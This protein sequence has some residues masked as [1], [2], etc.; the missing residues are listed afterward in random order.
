MPAA[1]KAFCMKSYSSMMMAAVPVIVAVMVVVD[2]GGML[3]VAS[4][5]EHE[6][7]PV[8]MHHLDIGAVE[9]GQHRAGRHL[10]HGAER[11]VA[12][13]EIE[14]PIERA[15]QLIEFVGAEQHG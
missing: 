1:A 5:R 12:V 11:G 2:V 3:D 9:L 7:V 14:H 4:A 8:R 13:A 6:H 10:R 15:D